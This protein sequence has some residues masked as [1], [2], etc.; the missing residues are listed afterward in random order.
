MANLE[1]GFPLKGIDRNWANSEQPPLTSPYLLNVRPKD[2]SDN[3][4]RGGQRPGLDKWADGDL[5]GG[6]AAP[7]VFILTVAGVS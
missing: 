3:R 4:T 6:A 5:I 2:V 7:V 1:I